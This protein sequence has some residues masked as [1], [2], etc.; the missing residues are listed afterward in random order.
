[1]KKNGLASERLSSEVSKENPVIMLPKEI[2]SKVKIMQRK[3]DVS[4]SS[5]DNVYENI[6]ILNQIDE[7]PK[8]KITEIGNN[9][10]QHQKNVMK[11]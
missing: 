10:L 1:M 7:I 9:A 6:D 3:L 11:K 5:V 2:H 4:K 8:S